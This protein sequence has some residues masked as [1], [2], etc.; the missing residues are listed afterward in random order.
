MYYRRAA[1]RIIRVIAT[2]GGTCVV[3]TAAGLA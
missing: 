1:H 3:A 2:P